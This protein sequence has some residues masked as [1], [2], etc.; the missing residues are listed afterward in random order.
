M[1]NWGVVVAVLMLVLWAIGTW[2]EWGGWVA[3]LLTG[4]VFLLVYAIVRSNNGGTGGEM[5]TE[6]RRQQRR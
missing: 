5:R 3:A 4:G 1:T 6:N 2:L